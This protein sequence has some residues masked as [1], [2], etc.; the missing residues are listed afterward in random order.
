VSAPHI[1]L[2]TSQ[3][4]PRSGH[5]V[6]GLYTHTGE[7][8]A[9]L[10]ELGCTVEVLTLPFPQFDSPGESIDGVHR[11]RPSERVLAIPIGADAEPTAGHLMM[12]SEE[13][14]AFVCARIAAGAARP[15][16]FHVHD[17]YLMPAALELRRRLG[18]PVVLSV[19]ILHAPLRAWWGSP[20]LPQLA[21]LE[22]MACAEADAVIT[23]SHSMKAVLVDALGIDAS[24]VHVVH[25]GFDST[26][27]A[28]P[29]TAA[30]A[31]HARQRLGVQGD[32]PV[33][34]YAGRLT[35]QKGVVPLLRS[36]V[37]VLRAAPNAIY[38]LAGTPMSRDGQS[39]ERKE[40]LDGLEAL[41]QQ[42]PE[43]A[44]RVRVLG[45]LPREEL[46]HL[47]HVA[48][49]AVVPSI[50][51]PFG[52]AAVEAVMAGAPVVAAASGGLPEI[53]EHERSGLLVPVDTSATPHRIDEAALAAAQL[54][55]L[56]D[57]RWAA[58][59]VAQGQRRVLTTFT[60]QRM[61]AETLAAVQRVT[62]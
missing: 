15:S 9:G 59:L 61:A 8:F 16:V 45:N 24:K 22:K 34:V 20:I 31:A 32:E 47:Y 62:A 50:Y 27:F 42:H 13:L 57:R 11:V 56:K 26:V 58:Q 21:G 43:L 14:V 48:T 55:V 39:D 46:A 38:A 10:T 1:F 5:G 33:V 18:I 4:P 41:Y 52:Y 30:Q 40:L 7:L 53:I 54:A 36:A 35:R 25:N 3:F 49:L 28:K 29:P 6:G 44:A 60:R 37:E 17:Y 2:L 19:H 12:Y 51:E 23:V